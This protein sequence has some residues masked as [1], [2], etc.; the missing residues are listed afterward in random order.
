MIAIVQKKNDIEVIKCNSAEEV[1]GKILNLLT[2]EEYKEIQK[3]AAAAD[4]I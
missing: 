4:W 3:E 2:D 1:K